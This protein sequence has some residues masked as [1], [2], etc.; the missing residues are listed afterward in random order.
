MKRTGYDPIALN[1]RHQEIINL[2]ALGIPHNVVAESLNVHPATVSN[3]VNSTL[4]REKLA[5]IRGARDADTV[6]IAKRM[7]N[8]I[9]KALDVYDKILS[10]ESDLG[11]LAHG[12]ADIKLQEKT[13]ATI[14]RDF[15]GLA[16]PK[17]MVVGHAHLTPDLIDEI[18]K[19]GREAAKE[20]GLMEIIEPEYTKEGE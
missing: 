20:C 10:D 13:A 1:D 12:G 18:K 17:K 6:D 16:V 3:A 7:Q 4:G 8:L 2:V 19:Q 5:L 15:S 11:K 9:P 14:L